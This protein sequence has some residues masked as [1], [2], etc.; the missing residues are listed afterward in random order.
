MNI[1]YYIRINFDRTNI[2]DREILIKYFEKI[3]FTKNSNFTY[4]AAKVDD[5]EHATIEQ[6]SKLFTNSDVINNIQSGDNCF[7]NTAVNRIIQES[8]NFFENKTPW[9]LCSSSCSAQYGSYLFD[10]YGDI[11]PCLEIV[12]QKK[13]CIGNFS[14]KRIN[15]N[16]NKDNWHSCHVGKN[17]LCKN[18]KYALLCGG[19]CH[20][21]ALNNREEGCLTCSFYKSAF[22][23]AINYSYSKNFYNNH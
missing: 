3:G 14:N 11:Y 15:W 18:C 7:A 4:H 22:S 9:K 1:I 8:K 23:R 10:P 16:T 12:G 13:H 21:K 19:I 20:A 17:L 5:F 6:D 2:G